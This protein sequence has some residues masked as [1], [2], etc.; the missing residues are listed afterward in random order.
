[1]FRRIAV[2][3]DESAQAGRAFRAALD[4]AKELGSELYLMT[5]VEDLPPYVGYVSTVA[6]EVPRLLRADRQ[7]CRTISFVSSSFKACLPH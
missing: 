5:V 4:L 1:M 7:A 2:G 3:F 6:P